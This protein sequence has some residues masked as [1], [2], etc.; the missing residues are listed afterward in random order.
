M[1]QF[2]LTAFREIRG[3]AP[4]CSRAFSSLS[5][6]AIWCTQ[7]PSPRS[8]A[9]NRVS[10]ESRGDECRRKTEKEENSVGANSDSWLHGG[11]Q[12]RPKCEVGGTVIL[13]PIRDAGRDFSTIRQTPR[14]ET[15][16]FQT[17]NSEFRPAITCVSWRWERLHR[18]SSGKPACRLLPVPARRPDES[19]R[20]P[21]GCGH[22]SVPGNPR[23]C[24]SGSDRPLG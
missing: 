15:E 20:Q 7:V 8:G 19:S 14:A 24:G 6:R 5:G 13:L 21:P 11:L 18:Q 16:V 2:D 10:Y 12:R 1:E 23:A 3:K 4:R 17:S 22:V 9:C